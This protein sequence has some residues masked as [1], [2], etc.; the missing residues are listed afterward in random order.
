MEILKERP[1]P[2]GLRLDLLTKSNPLR[3]ASRDL[4]AVGLLL[5]ARTK[6][7]V[8]NSLGKHSAIFCSFSAEQKNAKFQAIPSKGLFQV[9]SILSKQTETKTKTCPGHQSF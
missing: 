6:V 7:A 5:D 8:S 3:H 2:G 9:C 4:A 1:V